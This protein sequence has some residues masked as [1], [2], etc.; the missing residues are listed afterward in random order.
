MNQHWEGTHGIPRTHQLHCVY[1]DGKWHLLVGQVSTCSNLRRE[2]IRDEDEEPEIQD[3]EE[4]PTLQAFNKG[5]WQWVKF[6]YEGVFYPGEIVAI[7][8]DEI[9]INA[10]HAVGKAWKWP[11]KKDI[12][13]YSK[14]DIVK[15]ISPPEIINSHGH[16]NFQVFNCSKLNIHSFKYYF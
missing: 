6:R 15:T 4:S 13:R 1:P 14:D 5:Q 8:E 10:M 12:L 11:S 2:W 3:E 7:V 9:E 16:L